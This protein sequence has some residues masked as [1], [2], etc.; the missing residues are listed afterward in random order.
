LLKLYIGNKVYSSWSLRGWLAVMQS[1]LPFEEIVAPLYDEAWAQRRNGPEFAPANGKVPILW[2]GET[3]VWD[4]LAILNWLDRKTGGS[5]YWPTDDAAHALAR[6]MAAEM[7][8][9]YQALRGQYSMNLRVRHS[10]IAPDTAVAADIARITQLW[11]LARS[12]FGV[13]AGGDFLFGAFGA[14]DILFAPVVTRLESYGFVVPE[15]ARAYMDAVLSHPFMA[16]WYAEAAQEPWV[17]ERFER[18]GPAAA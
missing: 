11:T 9:G 7:H 6:S 15:A 17:I 10:G 1:G 2:D 16:R 13:P 5:R 18:Y 8:S 14:A 3:A 12:Q 4:S